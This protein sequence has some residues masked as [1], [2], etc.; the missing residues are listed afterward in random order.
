MIAQLSYQGEVTVVSL[1]GRVDIEKAAY[2]RQTC[3]NRFANKKIVFCMDR[4]H[5]VGSSG[6]QNLFALMEELQAL[7]GCDVKM[8]GLNP[9]F[10]RLWSYAQRN[11]VL[12]IHENLEKAILS[13]QQ[14]TSEII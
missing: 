11:G 1:S 9:D 13:F 6:I 2:L 3:L 5:F 14:P 12:E 4:L 8:A 7:R 10:Q